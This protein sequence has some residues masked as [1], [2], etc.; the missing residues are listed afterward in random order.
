MNPTDIKRDVDKAAKIVL[1]DFAA[2]ATM[3]TWC[4]KDGVNFC[5][6]KA[7]AVHSSRRERSCADMRR[8]RQDRH[9]SE[10][11]NDTNNNRR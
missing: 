3:I 4:G 7:S 2:Q 1:Q 8:Q 9:R 5:T 10:R 6:A 11:K